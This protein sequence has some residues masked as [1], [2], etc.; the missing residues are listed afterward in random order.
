M[1]QRVES[2]HAF[3]G[4]AGVE[5]VK[6]GREGWELCMNHSL[7][8]HLHPQRSGAVEVWSLFRSSLWSNDDTPLTFGCR[9]HGEWKRRNH[10]LKEH[11][12]TLEGD[13][14]PAKCENVCVGLIKRLEG[15]SLVWQSI[16][17]N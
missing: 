4:L 6:Q 15:G 16:M 2:V 17:S 1:S 14:V 8:G 10:G 5:G 9:V 3:V 13:P 7:R 12:G 11:Q